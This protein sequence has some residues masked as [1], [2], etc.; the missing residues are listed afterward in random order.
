MGHEA[1]PRL[2]DDGVKAPRSARR[3][4]P[5]EQARPQAPRTQGQRRQPRQ[6]AQRL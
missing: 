2:W 5:H 4:E 1:D 3:G 6:E